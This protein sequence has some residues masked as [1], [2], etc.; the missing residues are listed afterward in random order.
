MNCVTYLRISTKRQ[1]FLDQKI[2]I[3]NYLKSKGL[4]TI[5]NFNDTYSGK[6]LT[7]L[8]GLNL[9]FEF[10]KKNKI[11]DVIVFSID[12]FG[13][14]NR[15]ILK[16]NRF[17]EDVNIHSILEDKIWTKDSNKEEVN[18]LNEK[19]LSAVN[20]IEAMRFKSKE[21]YKIKKMDNQYLCRRNMLGFKIFKFRKSNKQFVYLKF[22]KNFEDIKKKYKTILSY[23][24]KDL[25]K[26]S[27]KNF[28]KR[29]DMKQIKKDDPETNLKLII[30]SL[31][32]WFFFIN[33][34]INYNKQKSQDQN[35]LEVFLNNLNIS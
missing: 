15:L 9:M 8:S 7:K 12:R 10:C 24:P 11:E 13:R 31:S 21:N 22:D 18:L 26:V 34:A 19:I 23:M 14:D 3:E 2:A 20:F 32:N 28:I 30:Y 17:L 27:N 35:N 25:K 16:L 29:K 6:D 1:S 33:L 4:K 5:Q